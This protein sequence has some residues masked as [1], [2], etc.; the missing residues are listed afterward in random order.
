VVTISGK[1]RNLSANL[2]GYACLDCPMNRVGKHSLV[3]VSG[4]DGEGHCN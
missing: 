2:L 3:G 1:D 4:C